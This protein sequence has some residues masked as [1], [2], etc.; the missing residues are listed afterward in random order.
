MR[1]QRTLRKARLVEVSKQDVTRC[2]CW[3][4]YIVLREVQKVKPCMLGLYAI[5]PY[6]FNA[7]I[8]HISLYIFE[9]TCQICG[10]NQ[11]M[12]FHSG[13]FLFS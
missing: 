10:I 2:V 9:M 1:V 3:I 11:F 13:I 6:C 12:F 7:T 8:V 4:W 5:K